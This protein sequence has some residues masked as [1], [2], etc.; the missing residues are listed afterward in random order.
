MSQSIFVIVS[1]FVL[2]MENDTNLAVISWNVNLL[3]PRK[4]QMPFLSYFKKCS[5]NIGVAVNPRLSKS[6]EEG[7]TKMLGKQIFFNSLWSNSWG[8]A[9]IIKDYIE[10]SNIKFKDIIAG[11]LSKLEFTFKNENTSWTVCTRQ[12]GTKKQN[13]FSKRCLMIVTIAITTT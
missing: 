13:Y 1:Q 4:I 3:G 11:N 10:L 12:T 7:F 5:A 2:G 9:V 8:I 6:S